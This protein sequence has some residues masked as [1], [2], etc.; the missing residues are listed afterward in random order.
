MASCFSE[1]AFGEASRSCPVSFL[2]LLAAIALAIASLLH[3]VFWVRIYRVYSV[4][5]TWWIPETD[6]DMY[7]WVG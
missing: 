6:M 4:V 3:N 7:R 2:S 1:D 5:R